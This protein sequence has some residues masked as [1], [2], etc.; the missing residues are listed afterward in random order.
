MKVSTRYAAVLVVLAAIHVTQRMAPAIHAA[1]P[2]EA[3]ACNTWELERFAFL[4]GEWSA[5]DGAGMRVETALGGCVQTE[6]WLPAKGPG[7]AVAVWSFDLRTGKLYYTWVSPAVPPQIW[8]GRSEEGRWRFYREWQL[9]GQTILSRVS[10]RLTADGAERLNEQSRDG[11]K[12]WREHVRA[13]YK[14]K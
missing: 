5:D 2:Q 3:P 9:D 7:G 6:L 11:G 12:T 1:Q 4:L 10:W 14:R 8:E 13:R